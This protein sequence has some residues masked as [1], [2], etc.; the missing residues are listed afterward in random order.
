[1]AK[2]LIEVVDFPTEKF[3]KFIYVPL[4]GVSSID[5]CGNGNLLECIF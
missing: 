1:M 2:V 3:S 5:S 4:E